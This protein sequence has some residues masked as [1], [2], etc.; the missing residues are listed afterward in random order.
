M[1]DSNLLSAFIEVR[2]LVERS[3]QAALRNVNTGLIEL[4]WQVGAHIRNKIVSAAWGEGVVDQL[5]AYLARTQPGLRGFTR[6]NLFRMRQFY[7][8]YRDD[9]KVS[10]LVRQLPWTQNLV[11]LGQCKLALFER[12]VLDPPMAT[13]ILAQSRPEALAAFKDSYVVEFLDRDHRKPHENPAIGLLLCASKD[14][15]VVEYSP[16]RNLSPAQGKALGILC[17]GVAA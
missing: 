9:E 11:I 15:E 13:A 4:Y 12:S 10:P 3:R 16:R 14:Q 6:P 7:E 8:T 2:E 17:F 5:A 1:P